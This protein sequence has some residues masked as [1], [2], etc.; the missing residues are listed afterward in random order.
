[1]EELESIVVLSLVGL[2]FVNLSLVVLWVVVS[3]SGIDVVVE[4]PVFELVSDDLFNFVVVVVVVVVSITVADVVVSI[5]LAVVVAVV[6]VESALEPVVS[7]FLF[8]Y[9][10]NKNWIRNKFRRSFLLGQLFLC[11]VNQLEMTWLIEL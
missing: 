8:F 10:N 11:G 4:S 9:K 1:V 2:S 6:D 3:S 7:P 5:V